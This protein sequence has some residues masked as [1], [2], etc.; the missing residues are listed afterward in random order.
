MHDCT[1]V[2]GLSKGSATCSGLDFLKAQCQSNLEK[3]FLELYLRFNKDRE[4]SMLI[5]QCYVDP[6][7]RYRVDFALIAEGGRSNGWRWIAVEIDSP[8][9]HL[10]RERDR[11]RLKAI[12]HEGYQVFRVPSVTA[13]RKLT[14]SGGLMLTSSI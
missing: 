11:L 14:S 10:D 5:P 3:M 2:S 4:G 13:G 6:L 12:E 7:E 9:Y 8:E 1:V